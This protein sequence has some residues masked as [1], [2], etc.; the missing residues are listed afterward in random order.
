VIDGEHPLLQVSTM[1]KADGSAGG[2]ISHGVAGYTTHSAFYVTLP[3][4][5]RPR[6][7]NIC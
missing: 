4:T 5:V 7:L 2:L 3:L 6:S 1:E